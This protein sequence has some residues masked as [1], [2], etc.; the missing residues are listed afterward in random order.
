M[1]K[2][3]LRLHNLPIL[4]NISIFWKKIAH[5]EKTTILPTANVFFFS[6]LNFNN[7]ITNLLV[8][9]SVG[10]YI[11]NFLKSNSPKT[12]SK[13]L[14]IKSEE[15]E[16]KGINYWFSKLYNN[17]ILDLG[18]SHFQVLSYSPVFF[19]FALKKKKLK[20]ILLLSFKKGNFHSQINYFRFSLKPVGPYKLK[21]FQFI[22][23]KIK[24]KEGKKPF[25]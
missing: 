3:L 2:N 11:H 15:L 10:H 25:K 20:K 8:I 9:S 4:W 23:E 22:N 17:I 5:H 19:F 13:Y 12:Y 24:L 16:L 21:G 1:K 18:C 14:F 7:V 6:N